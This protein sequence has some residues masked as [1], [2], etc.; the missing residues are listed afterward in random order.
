M[1]LD[2]K[3]YEK[4]LLRTKFGQQFFNLRRIIFD[5]VSYFIA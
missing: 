1:M 4:H 2:E 3:E 5:G